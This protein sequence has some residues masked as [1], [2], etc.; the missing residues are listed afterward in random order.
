MQAKALRSAVD[1]GFDVPP[2]AIQSAIRCVREFYVTRGGRG[3][4]E[5]E[6]QKMNGQFTYSKGGGGGTIRTTVGALCRGG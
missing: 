6:Q 5:S 4:P 3:L 1:S 2:E